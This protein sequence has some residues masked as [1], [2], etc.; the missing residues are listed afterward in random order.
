MSSTLL[1]SCS[2]KI[3]ENAFAAC[4]PGPARVLSI[5]FEQL[6]PRQ[7][8]ATKIIYN[9]KQKTEQQIKEAVQLDIDNVLLYNPAYKFV[10][11]ESHFNKTGGIEMQLNFELK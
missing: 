3:P 9:Y 1:S 8:R 2:A 4:E 6:N 11:S 5:Q 10:N 7:L